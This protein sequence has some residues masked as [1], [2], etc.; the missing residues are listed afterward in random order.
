M[1][2]GYLYNGAFERN[3]PHLRPGVATYQTGAGAEVPISWPADIDGLR[4]GYMERR[5]K[6]FCAVRVQFE[7][8]DIVLAKPV[9]IDGMRHIG[10]RRLS[11]APT[12]VTDDLAS[13]LLDDIIEQN[14]EQSTVVA[15]MINRMNQ[16]RRGGDRSEE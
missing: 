14:P 13:A 8:H 5:G 2:H 12:I 16:V 9:I 15:L 1:R 3:Y 10:N 6:R 7:E 4:V 11:A